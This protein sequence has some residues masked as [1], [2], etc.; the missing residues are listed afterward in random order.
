[1]ELVPDVKSWTR[2]YKHLKRLIRQVTRHSLGADPWPRRKPA[3]RKPL[4]GID[5]PLSA[6]AWCAPCGPPFPGSTPGSTRLP[7]P[8]VQQMCLYAAAHLWWQIIG[9]FLSPQGF[10]QRL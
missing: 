4:P 10:A 8:R 6:Q 5:A 9:T 7:D 3:G 1:M 2:N